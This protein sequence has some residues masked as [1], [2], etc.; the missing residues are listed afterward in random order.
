MDQELASIKKPTEKLEYISREEFEKRVQIIARCKKD[1]V[2]WAE[3]FFRI[4]NMTRGLEI[5]KLYQKQKELL[6]FLLKNDRVITLAS[7]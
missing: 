7:R 6:E 4:V 2:W 3:N 1:I 5:I